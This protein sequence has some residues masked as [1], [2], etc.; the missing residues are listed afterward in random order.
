MDD[1]IVG[2]TIG[3]VDLSSYATTKKK[4]KTISDP[5]KNKKKNKIYF[6]IIAAC[7]IAMVALWGYYFSQGQPEEVYVAPTSVPAE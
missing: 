7:L 3:G 1:K 4:E 6:L 5:N 2:G